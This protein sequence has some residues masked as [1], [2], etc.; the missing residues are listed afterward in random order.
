MATKLL[1]FVYNECIY[2]FI[3]ALELQGNKRKTVLTLY[4]YVRYHPFKSSIFSI[5]V[6]MA[7]NMLNRFKISRVYY[8]R[9]S[10]CNMLYWCTLQGSRRGHTAWSRKRRVLA[11]YSGDRNCH[12]SRDIIEDRQSLHRKNPCLLLLRH[13]IAFWLFGE[14]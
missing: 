2:L 1:N 5:M 4:M 14:S 12:T 13:I 7:I 8:L 10:P 9:S 6:S 11:G 3:V